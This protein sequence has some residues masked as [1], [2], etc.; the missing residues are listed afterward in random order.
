M[1][2]PQIIL[3]VLIVID[4]LLGTAMHGKPRQNYSGPTKVVDALI[5]LGLLWWG[6]FFA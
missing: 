3:V 6:G 4:V 2:E 5:L 1:H